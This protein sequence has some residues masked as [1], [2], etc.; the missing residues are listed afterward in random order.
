LL[1]LAVVALLVFGQGGNKPAAAQPL[2][3]SYKCYTIT[4]DPVNLHVKLLTQFGVQD[5]LVVGKPS[6][7]CLPAGIG[8]PYPEDVP[9]L[10][11][12]N[13]VG[14]D[15]V[16]VVNLTSQFGIEDNVTVGQA[17][18]LCVPA[19]K[20][21][22]P[23]PP[24][25]EPPPTAAHYECY[26]IDGAPLG[27]TL[28]AVLT[29][30]GLEEG[31]VVAEPTRLCAP[32]LKNG[33]GDL[34]ATHL[35]CYNIVGPELVPPKVVNLTTQFGVEPNVSVGGP[36]VRL[37][38]PATKTVIGPAV[39]GIAE[40]PGLAGASAEETGTAAESSGWSAA[41]YAALA[42]GLAAAIVALSAGA[43]YARRR[44]IR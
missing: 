2:T 39:G 33:E 12:Y 27:A 30:F 44:L 9:H 43:W 34:S 40:G 16:A 17:L 41:S 11:C 13:I 31:V 29:Q 3:P 32:A 21:P 7:L 20:Q 8:Q 28:P 35:K 36:P 1:G 4:G 26:D 6:L 10:K 14:H 38:V 42:G 22:V 19:N 37:C 23:T 5:D 18:E 15:P 25:A 24:A